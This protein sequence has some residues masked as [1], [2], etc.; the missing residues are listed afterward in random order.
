MLS[1]PRRWLSGSFLQSSTRRG[2]RKQSAKRS[3]RRI[4]LESLEDRVVPTVVFDPVFSKETL[5]P[6]SGHSYTVLNSPTIYLD[7]WG[8]GWTNGGSPGSTVAQ[9]FITDAQKLINSTYFNALNQYGNIGKPVFGQAWIDPTNPPSGYNSGSN[10][11]GNF[12]ALQSEV[13]NAISHNPSWAPAGTSYTQSPIYVVVPVGNSGGYNTQAKYNGGTVNICSVTGGGGIADYYTEIL[14][15]EL[16]EDISD[17]TQTSSGVTLAFPTSPSF[18]GFINETTNPPGINNTPGLSGNIGYLNN[19]GVVQIGDGEAEPGGEAHYGYELNGVKVQALWSGNTLDKNGNPGA[20]VVADG[21]SQTVYLD[22][23]WTN[24]VIPNPNT[25]NPTTPPIVGP[26][27]TG[28]YNL[29][30]I[31]NS[32]SVNAGDA[33]TTVTVS[34]QSFTFDQFA[35][36]GQIQNITIETT[37]NNAVVNLEDLAT[38]Q[39][40]NVIGGESDTVNIGTGGPSSVSGGVQGAVNI[41][42]PNGGTAIVINDSGDTAGQ[43]FYVNNVSLTGAV[44]QLSNSNTI[45]FN[46]LQTSSLTVE[47]GT[48][49][50]NAIYVGAT[51]VTTNL[52]SNPAGQTNVSLGEAPNGGIANCQLIQGT[53]NV[54]SLGNQA[55]AND[56]LNVNDGLDDTPLSSPVILSPDSQKGSTTWGSITGLAPAAINYRYAAL[57]QLD[58]VTGNAPNTIDV[59]ATGVPTY[60]RGILAGTGG[61]ANDVTVGQAGSLQRIAGSVNIENP[62]AKDSI[63][64]DDSADTANRTATVANYVMRS[65]PDPWTSIEGLAHGNI[66][67]DDLQTAS[68]SIE[69][70]TGTNQYNVQKSGTTTLLDTGSG[71]DI[72]NLGNANQLQNLQSLLTII[73][74]GGSDTLNANDQANAA[75]QTYTVSST[76]LYIGLFSPETIDY[77]G[78]SSVVV[79]GSKAGSLYLLAST[80]AGT[81]YQVNAGGSNNEFVVSPVVDDCDGLQGALTLK[82]GGGT[83]SLTVNDQANASSEFYVVDG[84]GISVRLF[85]PGITYGGFKTV[86]LNGTQGQGDYFIYG[87]ASGTSYTFN[88][89]GAATFDV[90]NANNSLVNVR[91]Q[92]LL[93]GAL[94]DGDTLNVDDQGDGANGTYNLGVGL[95][96][97]SGAA[98]ITYTNLTGV[99]V[100]GGTGTNTYI[101]QASAIPTDVNTGTGMDAVNL[102]YNNSLALIQAPV[103]VKGQGGFDTL[104]AHDRSDVNAGDYSVNAG[105]LY[106][107]PLSMGITYAGIGALE[108]DGGPKGN[109]FNVYSTAAGTEYTLDGGTG[110][111]SF[112]VGSFGQSTLAGIQGALSIAGQGGVNTLDVD[113]QANTA[114]ADYSVNPAVLYFDPLSVGINYVGMKTLELDGGR[115]GNTFNVYGTAA[116]T[117]YTLNGG[118]GGAAFDVGQF[119]SNVLDAIKGPVTVNGQGATSTLSFDDQGSTAANTYTISSTALDREGTAAINYS[120]LS[121]IVANA[122]SGGNV[123]TLSGTAA[124]TST[125][126]NAGGGSDT[127]KMTASA[128]AYAGALTINGQSGV[129]TLDYSGFS[130][131]V[132]VDLPLGVATGAGGGISNILNVTG[133]SGNDLFVGNGMGNKLTGG[134]GRNILIAGDAP[135]TLTGADHNQGTLMVGG[136][137]NYDTNLTALDAIMAE[138]SDPTASYTVRVNDLLNGGGSNGN[139][140]LGA[141][142]FT[143]NGGGNSLIGNSPGRDLYYGIEAFDVND[144][145]PALGEVFVQN[146]S[147]V[148]FQISANTLTEPA[149]LLDGDIG[150]TTRSQGTYT[151]APGQHTLCDPYAPNSSVTFTVLADGTVTYSSSLG[152]VLGGQGTNTLIVNGATITINAQA[153]TDFDLQLD[154]EYGN[155]TATPF[156]VTILPGTHSLQQAGASG[157]VDFTVS[158]NGTVSYDPS[159]QGILS[160]QGTS[161]LKVNGVTVSVNAQALSVPLVQID[162]YI[163]END[164]S[165][166]ALTVLPGPQTLQEYGLPGTTINFT[167]TANGTVS[168]DP[169]LQGILSGQGTNTLVVNGVTVTVNAQALSDPYLQVDS[170]VEEFTAAPFTL[171]VLPGQHVMQEYI[172]SGTAVSFTVGDDGTVSYDP[173]LAGVFSGQGTNNLVVNGV[174]ISVNAQALSDPYVEIDTYI[175]EF[176]SA[177]FTLT[178]LPGQHV[179]EEYIESGT[180]LDFAL[181]AD[182]TVSYDPSLQGVLSG[183][184]TNSLVVNGVTI[185]VNAQKLSD[186]Y[187]EIDAYIEELTAAPFTL[188]VLPGQH[189]MEE[190]IESGSS[191]SFTV[192]ADGTVSYDPSLQGILSGQGTN[193]LVV[194]GVTITVNAQALSDSYVQIDT[195][196]EKLTAAPFA[197]TVLPGQQVMQELGQGGTSV[198]FAVGADGTVSYDPSLQGIL[199]GQGTNT[200]LVNGV[201]ITVN[202]QALSDSYVQIDAYIQ[203]A[204]AAPF[205]VTFLPGTQEINEIYQSGTAV[206]FTVANDGTVSYDPSL[207]GILSGQGTSNLMVNGVTITVN[208][209]ALS[210]TSLQF[211]SYIQESTTAPFTLTLLPGTLAMQEYGQPGTGIDLTVANDGTIS[212]ASTYNGIL[213]SQ[214]NNLVVYGEQLVVNATA[215]SSMVSTFSVGPFTNLSTAQVQTLVVLPGTYG[216]SAGQLA[217]SFMLSTTDQLSYDPSLNGQVGGSGTNTLVILS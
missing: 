145:K 45:T 158:D 116:G 213:S 142:Q 171:T 57:G 94:G 134:T 72:V 12:N 97:R 99:T 100:N 48:A 21:N 49:Q 217:F 112:D 127:I 177:P 195:Y 92:I 192:G 64:V 211:D 2:K 215:I 46:D 85:G 114:P 71:K 31:G 117:T 187:V 44:E 104:T 28:S 157:T 126:V 75:A 124:G 129:N 189:V 61:Y 7:L 203:D 36:G 163:T 56:F 168:Y 22:P 42:N 24:Q 137:T 110:G 136:T 83:S 87:T 17:P 173:S 5:V 9:T 65:S 20:Y 37:G 50:N 191:V 79:N 216:F 70:G 111:A 176:T 148:S 4:E 108:V 131:P 58:V 118:S 115:G 81:G 68:V 119:G 152:R 194:N 161:T 205:T 13:G 103:G 16:A 15:H 113:D 106:V 159:L 69:G 66:N 82:G 181:G 102:G 149:L 202:A 89:A 206:S 198:G 43:S 109:T 172:E 122:G 214:G 84:T 1:F 151:L 3:S 77:Q 78:M 74:Q 26:V 180:A 51:G 95:V 150:V 190:F 133:G 6:P 156:P 86:T 138:W 175:E 33:Q 125:T 153:L 164:T 59:E 212:F 14:S 25:G 101:I 40:V 183:Q 76:A 141:T 204:T 63:L 35:D 90:G 60:L 193:S 162:T 182:G 19:S 18:P 208:A 39:T 166:F 178:V 80:A 154:T 210:D 41:T 62:N 144:W 23:I 30:L 186:P 147:Q 184:G 11:N 53:V 73:G 143:N 196:V 185:A 139:Y 98:P 207:A 8:A 96:S 52:Y 67:F 27:F 170:F 128:A 155:T 174:T 179:I 121:S 34:N 200:L 160:G 32:I 54:S 107:R 88:S 201:T 197:L 47:T 130:G 91:G 93:N 132:T 29:T 199:S 38:D 167:V 169:S 105:V 188:T 165:P 209:Q 135:A 123:L 55:P 10:A 146:P 120:G 140:S